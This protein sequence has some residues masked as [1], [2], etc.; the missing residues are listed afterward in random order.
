VSSCPGRVMGTG[1][2][3]DSVHAKEPM[4]LRSSSRPEI[5]G[6]LTAR[7]DRFSGVNGDQTY[8][9][10]RWKHVSNFSLQF[11]QL[12]HGRRRD[13]ARVLFVQKESCAWYTNKLTNGMGPDPI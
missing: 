7:H 10:L 11:T 8:I 1:I 12:R 5:S 13:A 6:K 4:L 2:Y 3:R 9:V